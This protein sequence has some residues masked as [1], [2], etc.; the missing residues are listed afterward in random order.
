MHV[1]HWARLCGIP[2]HCSNTAEEGGSEDLLPLNSARKKLRW[3]EIQLQLS[4]PQWSPYCVSSPGFRLESDPPFSLVKVE[5]LLGSI[6]AE[7][8]RWA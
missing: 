1:R 5:S 6:P 2:L 3:I 4:S 7:S 8:S